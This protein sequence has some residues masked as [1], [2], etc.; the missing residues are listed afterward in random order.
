M[1]LCCLDERGREM[2]VEFDAMNFS[3]KQKVPWKKGK[4]IHG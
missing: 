2:K 1:N 3:K 4:I